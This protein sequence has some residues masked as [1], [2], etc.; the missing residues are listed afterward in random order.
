MNHLSHPE[1][2]EQ[3]T[4]CYVTTSIPYV[5]AQPHVGFALESIQADV[6][7][8]YH[9]RQGHVVRLQTGADENSLKNVQAAEQAG[10]PTALLVERNAR[11]FQELQTTLNLAV[12]DFIRTSADQRH[13]AGVEKFW[14]ACAARGD[15][16]RRTYQ[17]R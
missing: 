8:R 7:A 5:N 11:R 4:V 15:I 3:P 10:L 1:Q 17:G 14:R 2:H 6:L 13:A 9:R 16:Y 12:D